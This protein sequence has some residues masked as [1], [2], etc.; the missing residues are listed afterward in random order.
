MWD[1]EVLSLPSTLR[2]VGSGGPV[3]LSWDNSWLPYFAIQNRN[4][5]RLRWA[6]GIF[7]AQKFSVGFSKILIA[8]GHSAQMFSPLK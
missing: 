7:D 3:Q 2:V 1:P 8:C 5:G 4:K 6:E